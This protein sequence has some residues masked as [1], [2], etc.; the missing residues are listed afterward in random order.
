MLHTDGV[1]V[2]RKMAAGVVLGLESDI[3]AQDTG[4]QHRHSP[5]EGYDEAGYE[6]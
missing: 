4:L 3:D 6:K 2:V 1:I 5:A